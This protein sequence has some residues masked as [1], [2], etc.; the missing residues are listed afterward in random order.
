[1]SG[2]F[3]AHRFK[4]YE[5]I[6]VADNSGTWYWTNVGEEMVLAATPFWMNRLALPIDKVGIEGEIH[7]QEVVEIPLDLDADTYL[8]EVKRFIEEELAH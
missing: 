7:R 1:M 4:G 6:G 5:F 3:K 8:E 2:S